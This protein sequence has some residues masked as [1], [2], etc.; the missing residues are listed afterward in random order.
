MP[1]SL[2][3]YVHVP[4]CVRKCPYCDFNSHAAPAELPAQAYVA[5]LMKDLEADLGLVAGRSVESIFIGGGTPGLVT[6]AAAG[7]ATRELDAAWLEVSNLVDLRAPVGGEADFTVLE[8]VGTPRD[9][10]AE[11][12]DPRDHLELGEMLGAIDVERSKIK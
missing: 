10:T 11:G 6:A 1:R 4:W 7:E 2:A 3:L 8:T 12:F 9:F 5:A